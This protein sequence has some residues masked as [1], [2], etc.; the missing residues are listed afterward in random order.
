MNSSIRPVVARVAPELAIVLTAALLVACGGEPAPGAAGDAATGT[1]AGLPPAGAASK[2][3]APAP[4]QYRCPM[5][6]DVVRDAPGTC[7]V[8]G[9]DLVAIEAEAPSAGEVRISPAV[10]QNLGVRT[11]VATREALERRALTTGYVAFDERRVRQVQPRAEGWI[12][13]LSVRATGETVAPGQLLFTLYSPMLEAAQQE[14]LDALQI[15]NRELIEASGERLRALGLEAGAAERLARGGRASGRVPFHA[16][17]GGVVTA[18]EVREG[19]RVDPGMTALTITGLGSLWVIAQVPE[20]QAGWVRPGTVAELSLASLPGETLAGRVDY[21]YPELD[22][23]TRT[24]RARIVLDEPAAGIRPNMLATV[25]LLGEAGAPELTV[26]RSAL[27]RS[28]AGDRVIVALGE[29]RFA[30]RAVVAGRESGERVAIREG[31]ADG[32]R[33]VVAGQFLLDAE[34]NLRAGLERLD[35]AGHEGQDVHEGHEAHGGAPA[36]APPT[37]PDHAHHGH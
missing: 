36:T 1:G 5:H 6:P 20:S 9:M 22:P 12:E 35:S 31:L 2:L 15:G 29:G 25:A 24:L 10:V 19:A 17:I 21:V 33:V 7:P 32:E 34:A 8:C 16:P 26:P 37:A 27:I 30:P 18:L 28:G 11:A 3:A 13:S 23:E 4:T 14:Y